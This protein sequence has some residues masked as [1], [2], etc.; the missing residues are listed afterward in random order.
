MPTIILNNYQNYC[1]FLLLVEPGLLTW[2]V[3]I[4][5]CVDL[6]SFHTKVTVCVM[7]F[8]LCAIDLGIEINSSVGDHFQVLDATVIVWILLS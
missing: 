3:F 2:Y 7:L 6:L 1:K 8:V 5:P 4:Q